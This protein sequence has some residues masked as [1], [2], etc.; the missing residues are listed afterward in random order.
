MTL[1]S[2]LTENI[3]SEE[4]YSISKKMLTVNLKSLI[5]LQYA[6]SDAVSQLAFHI[7]S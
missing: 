7:M 5:G 4:M 1:Q 6:S 2:K 3:A